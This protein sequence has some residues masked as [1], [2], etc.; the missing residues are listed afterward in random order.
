VDRVGG[1]VEFGERAVQ[2]RGEFIE[3]RLIAGW[4][5]RDDFSA[6]GGGEDFAE[7]DTLE[8]AF[9]FKKPTEKLGG[10]GFFVFRMERED[11]QENDRRGRKPHQK[12]TLI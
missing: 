11:Q 7:I 10:I 9:A 2:D 4:I 6:T 1:V 5:D 3:P 12:L 8:V